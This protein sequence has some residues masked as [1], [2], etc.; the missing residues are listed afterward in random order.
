MTATEAVIEPQMNAEA[1]PFLRKSRNWVT[2]LLLAIAAWGIFFPTIR[3]D[4]IYY[5][6]VRILRD[7]PELYGQSSLASDLKA[8]FVT[9]FPR[10]EPLLVRDVTWAIESRIFGFGNPVG[11]HLGNVLLHGVVVALLFVFLLELTGRYTFALGVSIGFLILAIHTEPV[12]WI[13][14]LKDLLCAAF[15]LLALCAQTRRLSA[16]SRSARMVWYAATVLCFAAG[17]LSKISALTFPAVLLLHALLYP[18]LRGERPGNAPFPWNGRIPREGLLAIPSFVVTAVVYVWYQRTL[19]RMG[20]FERG[21][22]AHGLAHAWNLLMIDPC[23]LWLYLRQTF[24]PVHLSLIYT[25]PALL[26]GFP[27]WQIVLSGGTV[28]G[29]GGLGIWL[30]RRH[31]DLFFYYAAFFILIFP[32]LN[33]FYIGIWVAD[34]YL[35]FA[36]FCLLA[37]FW[38]A[39]APLLRRPQTGVRY[40]VGAIL[41][42]VVGVNVYQTFGYQPIWRDGERF[43]Q[44]HVTLPNPSPS[45]YDNLATYYYSEARAQT[46][47]AKTVVPMNKLAIVIDAG[48]AEFWRD[49]TQPPPRETFYLFFMKSLVQ[50]VSGDPEGALQSLQLADQLHPGF[51]DISLGLSRVYRR[52]ALSPAHMQ[53]HQQYA[54]AGRDHYAQYLKLA[55]RDR[56][57]P[58]EQAHELAAMEAECKGEHR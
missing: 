30:F 35:Y 18:Y 20:L 17:L 40:G 6:D 47:S 5:D 26:P 19:A 34:R 55:F 49:R 3:F 25:W 13:M 32:Y 2:T 12:A 21:Y 44:Y 50:E 57:V 28:V 37:L 9:S 27:P 42:V 48:L 14:G 10:E 52:L 58:E 46:D 15:M 16:E 23:G 41:A 53:Q 22:S 33:V 43:W 56:P 45:A 11:Y 1:R 7:H 51:P 54:C 4:Y 24:C 39:V 36:G 31:K 29:L 8:I 38:S